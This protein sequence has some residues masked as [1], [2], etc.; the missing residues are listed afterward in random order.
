MEIKGEKYIYLLM[1]Y[2]RAKEN[3]LN[4]TSVGHD[5]GYKGGQNFWRRF[6]I[7]KQKGFNLLT[8]TKTSAGFADYSRTFKVLETAGRTIISE[9]I[10]ENNENYSKN[11]VH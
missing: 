10:D 11:W 6:T 1:A 3:A 4:S 7:Y 9:Y 2:E 5:N 8:E